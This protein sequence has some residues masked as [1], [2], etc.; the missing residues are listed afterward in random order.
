MRLLVALTLAL[1]AT[2]ATAGRVHKCQKPNGEI[3]YTDKACSTK[4]RPQQLLHKDAP[5]EEQKVP[6]PAP[7]PPQKKKNK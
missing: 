6:A 4:N 2:T 7:P 3:Y 5:P 1:F